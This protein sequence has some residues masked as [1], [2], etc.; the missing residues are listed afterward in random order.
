MTDC[1]GAA[2]TAEKEDFMKIFDLHNDAPSLFVR[3]SE[4][5][6]KNGLDEIMAKYYRTDNLCGAVFSVFVSN[7]EV[8]SGKARES[9]FRQIDITKK[10]I[11]ESGKFLL[12]GG[13]DGAEKILN[14]G[15]IPVILSLEGAEP[16]DSPE[17]LEEFREA[18][19]SFLSLTWSRDNA[20][21]G[22]CRLSRISGEKGLTSKGK[23]LLAEAERLGV[24]VDLAHAGRKTAREIL[25]NFSGRV[26]ISHTNCRALN[27]LDRNADDEVI[28]EVVR[29]GG[30][31]GASGVSM[32]C[33]CGKAELAEHIL[34]TLE[35][36]NGKGAALGLDISDTRVYY[37][38]NDSYRI[39]GKTVEAF[40]VIRNYDD[41]DSLACV[42]SER[43]LSGKTIAE[44]FFGNAVGFFSK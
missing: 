16:I 8:F 32:L 35:L 6:I 17:R 36:G 3:L 40:D 11:N 21:A 20:Y 34:R 22:G 41:G 43:G 23:E 39:D 13:N 29:R 38:R 28:A 26:L 27:D 9:A 30:V 24:Y 19:I 2:K 25:E 31:V 15:K 44:V 42:L 12:A 10:L 14:E 37:G 7:C 1:L 18:G 4:G 5:E 33:G